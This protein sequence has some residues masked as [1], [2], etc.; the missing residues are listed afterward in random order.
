[1]KAIGLSGAFLGEGLRFCCYLSVITLSY[2][3]KRYLF[4]I[5]NQIEIRYKEI[6]FMPSK[7]IDKYSFLELKQISILGDFIIKNFLSDSL[8]KEEQIELQL[9]LST[10]RYLDSYPQETMGYYKEKYPDLM[11]LLGNNPSDNLFSESIHKDAIHPNKILYNANDTINAYFTNDLFEEPIA[12]TIK[13]VEVLSEHLDKYIKKEKLTETEFGYIMAF[14]TSIDAFKNGNY[15][16]MIQDNNILYNI[17]NEG[18][19]GINVP[20]G[21]IVPSYNK[22]TKKMNF[23]LNENN[24]SNWKDAIDSLD[25]SPLSESYKKAYNVSSKWETLK[26]GGD[27]YR[28]ELITLYD[29]FAR[30]ARNRFSMSKEKFKTVYDKGFLQNDYDEF[31][32]GSRTPLYIQYEA[33]ARSQ[34]LKAGYPVSDIS[35]LS[36]VYMRFKT[37]EH[38]VK[39]KIAY[40]DDPEETLQSNKEAWERLVA[41]GAIN[42]KTRLSRINA[43]A[44]YLAPDDIHFANYVKG[45]TKVKLNAFEKMALSGDVNNLYKALCGKKVDPD[46]MKSSDEFKS[47]KEALKK[48]SETDKSK[49]PEKYEVLKENAI[50]KTEKY[51]SYKQ[52]QMRTPGKKHTRSDTETLRVNTA[53]SILD[54]LKRIDK[55]DAF[56]RNLNDKKVKVTDEITYD[57]AKKL[58]DAINAV[59]KGRTELINKINKIK[60]SLND[61]QTDPNAI[62]VNGLK[63]EGSKYYQNMARSAKRCFELVNDPASSH[64]E[65]I[66]SLEALKKAAKAYKKDKEGIFSSIGEESPQRVRYDA[67][68]YMVENI[69]AL[70]TEYSNRLKGLDDFK[71]DK[72]VPYKELPLSDLTDQADILFNKHIDEFRKSLKNKPPKYDYFK[73]AKKQVELRNTL[74]EFNSFM[75]NNY[76]PD[77]KID[78]YVSL[79]PGMSTKE[80]AD[81]YITKKYLDKLYKPGINDNELNELANDIDVNYLKTISNHLAKSP[82]FKKAVSTFPPEKFFSNW[83][84]IDKRADEMVLLC[85]QNVLDML[86]SRPKD[87][88]NNPEGKPYVNVYDYAI[89]GDDYYARCADV[90]VNEIIT[91]PIGRTIAEAMAADKTAN[92]NEII[93]SLKTNLTNHLKQ[94]NKSFKKGLAYYRKNH[95]EITKLYGK[96]IKAYQR[97]AKERETNQLRVNQVK[98]QNSIQSENQNNQEPIIKGPG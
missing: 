23:V 37:L 76:N 31:V 73:I 56:E 42:E 97:G 24:K 74:T 27:A 62:F 44:N 61:S 32:N 35:I 40:I 67:A 95:E 12:D 92:P 14:K 6:I 28:S 45:R 72:N 51:L 18:V 68:K 21:T 10:F 47:M 17:I 19:A 94:E 9:S 75:G 15:K 13:A 54:G 5:L 80:L 52:K 85:D 16:N 8:E 84:K 77:K 1:M 70:I 78:Y 41:P 82:A 34:L 55:Q 36:Q 33:E 30:E 87:P 86:N 66:A 90:L 98:R 59:D 29:D 49:Y 20:K 25:G 64:A 3:I 53:A 57:N 2:D 63:G 48:L 43:M 46:F 11:D 83:E 69:P 93:D 65:I 50:K 96:M 71:T 38:N 79:K 89:N 58:V 81:A 88:E 91:T 60:K 4:Q 7:L 26:Q 39:L 22:K